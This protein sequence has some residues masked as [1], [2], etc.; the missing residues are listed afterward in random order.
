MSRKRDVDGSGESHVPL[1][2]ESKVVWAGEGAFTEVTLERPVARVLPEMTGEF[3]GPGELPAASLPVAVVW[4][5]TW[6]AETMVRSCYGQVDRLE[7][8][9]LC[10]PVCVLRWALR[11]EL[12][13]YVFPQP[14][15]SQLCVA[16]RFLAHD[17]RPRFCL[18]IPTSSCA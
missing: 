6:E 8:V 10:S 17:L 15:N 2:V 14:G 7:S 13:V 5:L 4:L 3:I 1:H 11:C 12:F 9:V 18:I 16:A